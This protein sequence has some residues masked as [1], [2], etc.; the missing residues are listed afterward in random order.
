LANNTLLLAMIYS[1]FTGDITKL[2]NQK[3][4]LF[5]VYDTSR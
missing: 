1:G 3:A 2:N 5:Y 4:E